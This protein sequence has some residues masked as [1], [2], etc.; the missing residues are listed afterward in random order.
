M[1]FCTL[2]N[3]FMKEIRLKTINKVGKQYHVCLGNGTDNSFT[4]NRDATYFLAAT[5]NFLTD[6]LR[7]L[8]E[9][10]G[11]LFNSFRDTWFYFDNDRKTRKQPLFTIERECNEKLDAIRSLLDITVQRSWFTN[12][13]YFVF[14]NFNKIAEYLEEGIRLLAQMYGKHSNTNG[15][16][17]MDVHLRRVMRT[18]NELDHYGKRATTRLFKIPTHISENKNYIPDFH[19]LRVA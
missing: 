12:G 9:S 17:K 5:N 4:S 13:N 18:R 11:D 10:Y 14:I 7:E 16:G 1:I 2:Q 15:I 19:E 3:R 8:H 6:K